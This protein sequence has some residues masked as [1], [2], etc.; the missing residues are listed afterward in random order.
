MHANEGILDIFVTE[1]NVKGQVVIIKERMEN[2][3]IL[4]DE[5]N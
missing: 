2:R 1:E 3:Q 4:G 5:I